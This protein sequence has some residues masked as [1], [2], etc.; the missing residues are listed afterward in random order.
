MLVP[1]ETDE[2]LFHSLC[3]SVTPRLATWTPAWEWTLWIP[4]WACPA[5]APPP[6]W[7]PTP[8]TCRTSTRAW[9]P[10]WPVCHQAPEPWTAW[11]Q[12]WPPWAQPWAPV[13]V[14]WPH[15][16][17]LWTPWHPTLTWTPWAPFTD[18]LTSTG[19][20]TL[21]P[22]A[23][24]TRTPNLRIPTSLSSLWPSSRLPVRCWHWPRSTSG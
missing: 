9:V 6:T 19:P 24:A 14:P 12:A 22:T 1:D 5:W 18:S 4:T 15:S 11:A 17:R 16:L 13:W 3:Y 20:G 10:P 8:W 2:C 7:R 23:G 21:R